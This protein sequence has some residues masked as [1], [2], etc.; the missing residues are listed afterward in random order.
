MRLKF[1]AIS[2]LSAAVLSASSKTLGAAPAYTIEQAVAVAQD[3]SPGMPHTSATTGGLVSGGSIT[4]SHTDHVSIDFPF[5]PTPVSVDV[6]MTFIATHGGGK[7][8]PDYS[9]CESVRSWAVVI[10][11]IHPRFQAQY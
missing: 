1:A 5:G 2:M 4:S 10:A 6:S 9:L 3:T 7:F 11:A 8:L